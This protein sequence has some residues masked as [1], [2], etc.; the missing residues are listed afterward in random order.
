MDCV[1][2]C[3]NTAILATVA[4][5]HALDETLH[6]LEQPQLR[7]VLRRQFAVTNKYN[8]LF[9]KR[10]ETGGLLGLFI[11]PDKC[12]GCGECVTACGSHQALRMVGKSEVELRHFDL[13]TDLLHHPPEKAARF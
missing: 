6:K 5:P 7:D 9:V 1:N 11:D 8:D 10:G 2:F 13:G 12:K 4:E 3:P